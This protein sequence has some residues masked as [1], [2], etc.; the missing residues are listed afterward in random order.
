MF[1]LLPGWHGCDILSDVGISPQSHTF[2]CPNCT[3]KLAW[4][5]E[6]AGR[7]VICACGHR[8][9]A[10]VDAGLDESYDLAEAP[11]RP[12]LAVIPTNTN[13]LPIPSARPSP[14]RAICPVEDESITKWLV[15]PAILAG[16]GLIAR[17][18]F[19]FK[20][21]GGKSSGAVIG[22][23]LCET[24][25]SVGLMMLGAFIASMVLSI[26]FGSIG[27]AAIELTGMALAASGIA[28]AI[29][30]LDTGHHGFGVE[31]AALHAIVILYWIL[32]ATLFDL[33]FQETLLTTVIVGFV[34]TLGACVLWQMS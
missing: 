29:L 22:L 17:I 13:P 16:F 18:Y 10:I 8:F 24:I 12:A 20:I 11:V 4:K 34:Q 3:Q 14:Q 32:F 28:A 1:I 33:E 9:P 21:A 7:Y 31:T 6:Y 23:A 25:I 26:T 30:S 5:D 15:F 27:R 19:G 2:T